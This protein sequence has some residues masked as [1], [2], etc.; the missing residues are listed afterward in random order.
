MSSSGMW[1]GCL[2][3]VITM[4][5]LIGGGVGRECGRGVRVGVGTMIMGGRGLRGRGSASSRE[6]EGGG[7][8]S[9]GIERLDSSGTWWRQEDKRVDI[10]GLWLVVIVSQIPRSV[11]HLPCRH[12]P[13]SPV[14]Y[15]HRHLS[16]LIISK[17][18]KQ[19]NL[20]LDMRGWNRRSRFLRVLHPKYPSSM[21]LAEVALHQLV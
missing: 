9:T 8:G 12:K 7:G 17:R 2:V 19:T 5:G 13:H 10:S 15:I 16:Q 14:S 4:S 6:V 21:W 3:R 11:F 18:E 1:K 20:N